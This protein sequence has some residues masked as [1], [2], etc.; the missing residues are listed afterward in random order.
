MRGSN[1][2]PNTLICIRH[3]PVLE[4]IAAI[5]INAN[6]NSLSATNPLQFRAVSDW[7]GYRAAGIP[8]TRTPG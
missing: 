3:S 1:T 4:L 8:H 6:H 5:D 7:S 2:H